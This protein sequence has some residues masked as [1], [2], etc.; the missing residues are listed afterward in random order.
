MNTHRSKGGNIYSQWVLD[1]MKIKLPFLLILARFWPPLA[2]VKLGFGAEKSVQIRPW[3]VTIEAP[4]FKVLDLFQTQG[5][6][7]LSP[8]K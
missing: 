5:L 3:K 2:A 8:P 1:A 7:S 4:S 6:G